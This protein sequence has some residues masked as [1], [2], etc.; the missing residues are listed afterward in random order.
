MRDRQVRPQ[1]LHS[2][3]WSSIAAEA[4]RVCALEFLDKVQCHSTI[5]SYIHICEWLISRA[6][7]YFQFNILPDPFF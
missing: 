4:I 6:Q 3:V 2:K 7:N 1:R 5:G